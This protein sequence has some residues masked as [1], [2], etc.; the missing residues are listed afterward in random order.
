MKKQIRRLAALML[1]LLLV[2]GG[3]FASAETAAETPATPAATAED[4]GIIDAE[5]LNAWM[6]S[7]LAERG[8]NRDYI[9]VSVGFW[10]SGTGDSW[11]ITLFSSL[12][13]IFSSPCYLLL[14][15]R[16]QRTG[17]LSVAA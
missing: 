13:G 15:V 9:I 7:F 4:S 11:G 14:S 8:L 17:N 16:M 10:Y 12:M 2:S 3:V 6:D 1:A 5:E